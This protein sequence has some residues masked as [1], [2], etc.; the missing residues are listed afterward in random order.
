MFKDLFPK[1]LL[2]SRVPVLGHSAGIC[3]IYVDEKAQLDIAMR[4][5]LDAKLSYPSAW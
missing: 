3:H 1:T 5:V 4:V 2:K